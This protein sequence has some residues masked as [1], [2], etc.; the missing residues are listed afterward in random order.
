M[1]GP[2]LI[3]T[4][5]S[6]RL[7]TETD[8][9]SDWSFENNCRGFS[10]TARHSAEETVVRFFPKVIWK[11]S[12][13]SETAANRDSHRLLSQVLRTLRWMLLIFNSRREKKGKHL[14]VWTELVYMDTVGYGQSL[15]LF[16]FAHTGSIWDVRDAFKLCWGKM[17]SNFS[18]SN[19]TSINSC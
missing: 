15:Q 17:G 10:G 4:L 13:N 2:Q 18:N 5:F 7:W 16:L 3:S 19:L 11:V 1:T 9:F 8:R 12:I 14:Y 6:G